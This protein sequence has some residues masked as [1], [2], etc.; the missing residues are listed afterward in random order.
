M[1]LCRDCRGFVKTITVILN[2]PAGKNR[3]FVYHKKPIIKVLL[4][5]HISAHFKICLRFVLLLGQDIA[6]ENRH[7]LTPNFN[8]LGKKPYNLING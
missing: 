8:E 5:T 3:L 7:K 1:S 4:I 6:F 2:T